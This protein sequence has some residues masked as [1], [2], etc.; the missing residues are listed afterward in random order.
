MDYYRD[1]TATCYLY[2]AHRA[3]V[4]GFESGCPSG[5]HGLDR[6]KLGQR[7][8]DRV[9]KRMAKESDEDGRLLNRVYRMANC[10]IFFQ[11][12]ERG[13]FPRSD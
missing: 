9:A 1:L 4:Y 2:D 13:C 11:I 7:D 3:A 10:N 6:A 5:D 12:V 8:A